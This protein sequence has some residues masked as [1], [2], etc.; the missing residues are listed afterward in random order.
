MYQMNLYCGIIDVLRIFFIIKVDKLV[1]QFCYNIITDEGL[2][3]V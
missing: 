3:K 1:T 2:L